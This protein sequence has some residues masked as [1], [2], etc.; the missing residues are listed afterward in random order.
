MQK[1]GKVERKV[2]DI[3]KVSLVSILLSLGMFSAANAS[4]LYVTG[5]M[6]FAVQ[7]PPGDGTT[8][9]GTASDLSGR[10]ATGYVQT[11][12]D[13]WDTGIEVGYSYFGKGTYYQSGHTFDL[14]SSASDINALIGYALSEKW[15]LQ[16]KAGLAQIKTKAKIPTKFGTYRE[17]DE[18]DVKPLLGIGARYQLNEA[19]SF[20]MMLTHYFGAT[21]SEGATS[22]N[23]I[24]PAVNQLLLG[25]RYSF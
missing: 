23:N 15:V 22:S 8:T 12:N 25:V 13:K 24:V 21:S 4:G 16:A 17:R 20:E 10:L 14:T 19:L 7:K 9:I 6:G 1:I 3:L 18:H 11:I 2:G 5:S